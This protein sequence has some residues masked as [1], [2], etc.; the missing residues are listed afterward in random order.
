MNS[1]LDWND[2]QT[3]LLIAEAGTLSGAAQ[4][5]GTSHPTMFRRINAVEQKLGVRLFERFRTGY[6]LT[7]AGEEVAATAREIEELT[8]ATERRVAGRDL[9]PS[10]IVH[11]ATT[12]SLLW[13]LLA[14]EIAHLRHVEPDIV[15]DVTVSNE[16]S[17]LSFREA[18]IAIRPASAPEEHLIGRRLGRVRQAVY[19]ARSLASAR[20]TTITG[21]AFPGSGRTPPCPILSCT[22]GCVHPASKTVAWPKLTVC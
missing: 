13:G 20:T 18:D 16:I 9:R 17:D 11:L 14:P 8:N 2:Y 4:R 22:P 19:T 5:S 10:G 6:R 12:D 3:V 1:K 7:S 15:L 21:R